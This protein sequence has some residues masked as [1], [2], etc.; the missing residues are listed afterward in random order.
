MKRSFRCGLLFISI[1]LSNPRHN[2]G[3]EIMPWSNQSP[4][5]INKH[6]F[7]VL[8][9]P[10]NAMENW[11][12]NIIN[13]IKNNNNFCWQRPLTRN[14]PKIFFLF[15]SDKRLALKNFARSKLLPYPQWKESQTFLP[16]GP[17]EIWSGIFKKVFQS[18]SSTKWHYFSHWKRREFIGINNYY[19]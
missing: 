13:E 11:Q 7:I 9:C 18:K 5:K 1:Y 8:Q 3:D 2:R 15:F 6:L 17:N 12:L 14:S 10:E 16:S 4:V 19:W